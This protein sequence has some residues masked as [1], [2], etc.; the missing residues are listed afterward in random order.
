MQEVKVQKIFWILAIDSHFLLHYTIIQNLLQEK[1][2]IPPGKAMTGAMP[3]K[4]PRS[5]RAGVGASRYQALIGISPRSCFGERRRWC[6]VIKAGARDRY[7]APTSWLPWAANRVV[8]R[9]PVPLVPGSV[10]QEREAF[11]LFA[12]SLIRNKKLRRGHT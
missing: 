4:C 3:I 10:Y 12:L 11:Y 2:K 8:P 9:E 7:F 5:Q 1:G 6:P